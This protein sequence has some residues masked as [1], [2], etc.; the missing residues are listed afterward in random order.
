M[1]YHI[2]KAKGKDG[3]YVYGVD[4]TRHSK[5]PLTLETANKQMTAMNIAH[6]KKEGKIISVPTKVRKSK[7]VISHHPAKHEMV[8]DTATHSVAEH[9]AVKKSKMLEKVVEVASMAGKHGVHSPAGVLAPLVSETTGGGSGLA[10]DARW[11]SSV[12]SGGRASHVEKEEK[13]AEKVEHK[14]EAGG[15]MTTREKQKAYMEYYKEGK[16]PGDVPAHLKRGYTTYHR[17]VMRGEPPKW[18][19]E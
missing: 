4:G 15:K 19:K 12:H 11:V 9:P 1:P 8:K 16:M 2:K 6:A 5:S 13:K 3:F 14:A 17:K 10:N 7:V 18:H